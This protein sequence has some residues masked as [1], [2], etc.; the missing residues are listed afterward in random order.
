MIDSERYTSSHVVG[1]NYVYCHR[2]R[3][4]N[5]IAL[6]SDTTGMLSSLRSWRYIDTAVV[7]SL[8]DGTK[9]NVFCSRKCAASWLN[10]Q[11]A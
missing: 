7:V 10:S 4:E 11:E 3:C 9:K 2:R 1:Q 8:E 5:T 6:Q